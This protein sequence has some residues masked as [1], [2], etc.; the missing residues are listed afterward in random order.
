MTQRKC[1]KDS[2]RP[3]TAMCVAYNKTQLEG[4][5][6]IELASQWAHAKGLRALSNSLTTINATVGLIMQAASDR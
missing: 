1:F 5:N 4:T 6:C 2:T 3:C